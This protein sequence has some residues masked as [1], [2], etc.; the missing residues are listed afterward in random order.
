MAI[1]V[2]ELI[3]ARQDSD[4]GPAV[5]RDQGRACCR[6]YGGLPGTDSGTGLQGDSTLEPI[7]TFRSNVATPIPLRVDPEISGIR[8]LTMYP[9][10]ESRCLHPPGPPRLS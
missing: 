6:Q 1:E 10:P 8:L 7:L 2:D 5:D 9:R 4:F 3:A